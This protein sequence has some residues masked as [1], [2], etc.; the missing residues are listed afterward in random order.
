MSRS[1]PDGRHLLTRED[2]I[3][4]YKTVLNRDPEAEDVV[5]QLL[6]ETTSIWSLIERFLFSDEFKTALG[7]SRATRTDVMEGYTQILKRKPES[8]LAVE[9]HLSG[10]T[11]HWDLVSRLVKSEEHKNYVVNLSAMSLLKCIGRTYLANSFGDRDKYICFFHHYMFLAEAASP[12]SFQNILLNDFC[13]FTFNRGPDVYAITLQS[14]REL[15]NEGEIILQFQSNGTTIYSL[16]FS[17]VP[18][19]VLGG[20]TSRSVILISRLQGKVGKFEDMRL[21]TKAMGEIT[22]QISLIA[23]LQGIAAGG[24]RSN[25]RRRRGRQPAFV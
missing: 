8:E 12:E 1:R 25:C 17:I 10:G 9:H 7:Y 19:D 20:V 21:A 4:C 13:L 11:T 24:W 2:V 16:T 6:A 5:K 18:G 3:Q 15:D 22:P 14:D 23:A